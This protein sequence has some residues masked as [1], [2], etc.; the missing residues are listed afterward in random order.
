VNGEGKLVVTLSNGTVTTSDSLVGPAGAPGTNGSAGS[1]GADGADGLLSLVATAVE[2]AGTNCAS[3]GVR[4]NSG[5]DSNKNN[6]LDAGEV[7]QIRYVCNG[8]QGVPG[9]PGVGVASAEVNVAGQLEVVLT[10]GTLT[11]SDSLIGP[12]GDTGA[13]GITPTGKCEVGQAITEIKADGTVVCDVMT[14]PAPGMST[15]MHGSYTIANSVDIANLKGFTEVTGDLYINANMIYSLAGLES[16]AI[17]GGNIALNSNK[18]E[19]LQG[20][21]GL[22]HV[23]GTFDIN[24]AGISDLDGL[25][26]LTSV[27]ELHIRC[28]NLLDFSGLGSNL[29]VNSVLQ[30]RDNPKITSLAG[31]EGV[32][33]AQTLSISNNSQLTSLNG[34]VNI[35]EIKSLSIYSSPALS[36]LSTGA[37][38]Q[39]TNYLYLWET[40]VTSLSELTFAPTMGN[41]YVAFNPSLTDI[42][43]LDTVTTTENKIHIFDND[44]LPPSAL[45]HILTTTGNGTSTKTNGNTGPCP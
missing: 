29:I 12:Q 45:D 36:S 41:I 2:P 13:A 5:L 40:G 37:S 30:I 33:S 24:A 15:V 27:N 1:P 3:G 34:L 7:S 6:A 17:V 11:T 8:A 4:I 43:A 20:L 26:S 31:L 9:Q 28:Q 22:T 38:L 39:V 42:S 14:G 25:S 44:C 21:S 23:G 19:N 18:L 32:V 16:L 10:D 35:S